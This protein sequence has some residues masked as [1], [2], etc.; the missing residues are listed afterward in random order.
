LGRQNRK[1]FDLRFDLI[2]E[3][4]QVY[5]RTAEIKIKI[6][7]FK[8]QQ[9]EEGNNAA[10]IIIPPSGRKTKAKKEEEEKKKREC[11]IT[12]LI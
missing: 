8:T 6:R 10:C 2:F 7:G 1:R 4:D 11:K 9:H 3:R 5:D 12:F